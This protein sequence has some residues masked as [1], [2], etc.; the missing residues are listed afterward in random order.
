MRR[1]IITITLLASSCMALVVWMSQ[2]NTEPL[3]PATTRLQTRIQTIAPV[4]AAT[5]PPP[6]VLSLNAPSLPQLRLDAHGHLIIDRHLRQFFDAHLR[7]GSFDRMAQTQTMLHDLHTQLE[8]GD[9]QKAMIIFAN[10]ERYQ[11]A[12]AQLNQQQTS[13]SLSSSSKILSQQ[14]Q[15][16]QR[17]TQ[18][19]GA[20]IDQ[21]LFPQSHEVST[22]AADQLSILQNSNLSPED[23]IRQL[24][25]MQSRLEA[26]AHQQDQPR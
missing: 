26:F 13:T 7:H 1:T 22:L 23:R 4:L 6:S 19:L 18:Y 9:V 8:P 21:A 15:I 5:P 12:I 24:T 3:R 25:A 20:D 16:D 14:A 2:R 11:E 10:Y 17:R